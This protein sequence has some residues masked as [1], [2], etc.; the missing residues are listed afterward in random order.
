MIGEINKARTADWQNS[1]AKDRIIDP[2]IV[3]RACDMGTLSLAAKT[4]REEV[5]LD[6]GTFAWKAFKD[7]IRRFFKKKGLPEAELE[8]LD[9]YKEYG[10]MY[11]DN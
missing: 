9:A 3:E 11:I 4:F 1:T 7:E 2:I 5:Q 6:W 10:V 8:P